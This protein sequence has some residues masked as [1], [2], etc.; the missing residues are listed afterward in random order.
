MAV[1]RRSRVHVV[2]CGCT[3]CMVRGRTGEVE[4][5][6]FLN[7]GIRGSPLL[8]SAPKPPP[9][10][11][12]YPPHVDRT[13]PRC[14][15][16]LTAERGETYATTGTIFSVINIPRRARY[17]CAHPNRQARKEISPAE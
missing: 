3:A 1:E 5:T 6:H 9:A 15:P 2:R 11:A 10:D 8:A 12:V 14:Q 13:H 7:L 17:A 4:V 16:T